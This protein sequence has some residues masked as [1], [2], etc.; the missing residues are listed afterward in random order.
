MTY[1]EKQNNNILYFQ[2]LATKI[3][4]FINFQLQDN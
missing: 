2:T 3:E 1:Y 4:H